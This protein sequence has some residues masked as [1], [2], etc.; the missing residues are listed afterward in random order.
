MSCAPGCRCHRWRRPNADELKVLAPFMQ[1]RIVELQEK[2][3]A[4]RTKKQR[5]ELRRL[6]TGEFLVAE[7]AADPPPKLP[8]AARVPALSVPGDGASTA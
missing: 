8:G 2:P 5:V 3:A 4:L 1:R 6:L 7:E